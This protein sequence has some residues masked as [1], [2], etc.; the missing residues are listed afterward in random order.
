[1]TKRKENQG[2]HYEISQWVDFELD[3]YIE[4]ELQE[5]DD[6][7][8]GDVAL[9]WT[10]ELSKAQERFTEAANRVVREWVEKHPKEAAQ[11]IESDDYE[12]D[13]DIAWNTWAGLVGHGVGFWENMDSKDF[14]SLEKAIKSDE[15]L[16][17]AYRNL[18]NEMLNVVYAGVTEA[19][20]APDENP[21]TPSSTKK[22]KAKLLR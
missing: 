15:K 2:R 11:L 16:R 4:S 7:D 13:D 12:S 10:N 5:R 8:P 19:G 22:L 20:G 18:E 21:A 9:D 6:L 1:M 3:G 14:D 17:E